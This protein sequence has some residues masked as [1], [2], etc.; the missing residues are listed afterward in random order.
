MNIE[1]LYKLFLKFPNISIDSRNVNTKSIFV[2]LKGDH[3]DGNVFT[4]DALTK[5]NLAIIDNYSITNN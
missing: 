1:N 3:L 5:C 4:K 2:A